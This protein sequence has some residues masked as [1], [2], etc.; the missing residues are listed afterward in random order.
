MMLKSK[1]DRSIK[2]DLH[3]PSFY[4]TAENLLID[5]RLFNPRIIE[6]IIPILRR[7]LQNDSACK[8]DL[9]KLRQKLIKKF[10][11]DGLNN[12]EIIEQV[13]EK[14][15][16]AYFERVLKDVLVNGEIE[17]IAPG[18]GKTLCDQARSLVL[19][20][21]QVQT[22]RDET[23]D[24]VE[25]YKAELRE[26]YRVRSLVVT[27]FNR[28]VNEEKQRFSDANVFTVHERTVEKCKCE[29]LNQ[30]AYFIQRELNFLRK[31]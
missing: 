20:R 31:V 9:V 13:E 2:K 19:M 26:K 17:K 10:K 5:L 1:Q 15:F 4:R 11:A 3:P 12:K 28:S 22:M 14:L 7:L 6:L 18:I 24:Y 8:N 21:A 29:G 16:E 30:A 27:W 25:A 23:Y